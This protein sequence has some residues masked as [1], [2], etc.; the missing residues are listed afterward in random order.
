MVETIV[1][2]LEPG[3]AMTF[4]LGAGASLSSG[5]PSSAQVERSLME[6]D[7]SSYPDR[8]ALLAGIA[9]ANNAQ[10]L[11]PIRPLFAGVRPFIGYH[12]LAAIGRDRPVFVLNLNWDGALRSACEAIDVDFHELTVDRDDHLAFRRLSESGEEELVEGVEPDF[13]QGDPA[14]GVYCLHIHGMIDDPIIGIRFGKYETLKFA[15]EVKT[16]LGRHF[17][18]H[19]AIVIGASLE[20]EYDVVDLL[21]TLTTEPVEQR[22]L[23][24]PMY[25]FSR[26]EERTGVPTDKLTQHVLYRRTPGSNFRGD[27]AV[28]FDRLMLELS[29]R[30]RG[31][32]L[33]SS[34]LDAGELPSLDQLALPSREV[35]G[36]PFDPERHYAVVI[37]GDAEVGKTAAVCL[38]AHIAFLCECEEPRIEVHRGPVAGAEALE[39]LVAEPPTGSGRCVVLE[40]PFGTTG[41]PRLDPRFG[42]A[43]AA[44]LAQADE[45]VGPCRRRLLI[46]TRASNWRHVAAELPAPR[47]LVSVGI[48]DWYSGEELTAYLESKLL[49]S[50]KP[51]RPLLRREIHK[52]ELAL[53]AAIEDAISEATDCRQEIISE[54]TEFLRTISEPAQWCAILARLQELWPGG[55]S[56]LPLMRRDDERE[57]AFREA[58]LMLRDVSLDGETY[59]VPAHSTDREAIDEF[60]A[61]A[62]TRFEER[63]ADLARRHGPAEPACT[64]WKAIGALRSGDTAPLARLPE[65]VRANWGSMFLEEAARPAAPEE[66][67]GRVGAVRRI[68]LADPQSFWSRRELVFETIRLWPL[69][70]GERVVHDF[71]RTVLREWEFGRYLVLEAMLYVQAA[72]YP[73]AWDISAYTKIWDELASARHVLFEDPQAHARELALMF[74]A[75]AWCPPRLAPEELRRWI[76]P[77]T[78]AAADCPPLGAGIL[79][80][81]IYHPGGAEAVLLDGTEI[82]ERHTFEPADADLVAFLVRW[83]FVHQSRARALVYRRDLEPAHAYLLS[84]VPGPGAR[85]LSPQVAR[86]ARLVIDELARF[87]EHRGWAAHMAVGLATTRLGF[88]TTFAARHVAALGPTDPGAI[89][90]AATYR[91][92]QPM[93]R[94]FRAY[95][96]SAPNREALLD[97]LSHPLEVEGVEVG[98]PP[99]C[100]SRHPLA[101]YSSLEF[102]WEKLQADGL[103]TGDG[104]AMLEL[105]H[106]AT[107][108]LRAEESFEDLLGAAALDRASREGTS[109]NL[110]RLERVV[111]RGE[112]GFPTPLDRLRERLRTVADE[113]A[114]TS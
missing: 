21:R 101:L 5:A 66:A 107:A 112:T 64:L 24:T 4:V 90:A 10:K 8:D 92:P 2:H 100:A 26:Q 70:R 61:E 53:P 55:V 49:P 36:T 102:G 67:R 79:A 33:G 50:Q 46:T 38:I 63:L 106:R 12:C 48:D 72:T 110:G 85:T 109:G 45:E 27:P 76:E 84:R 42:P 104:Y 114:T 82:L 16:L 25:V 96:R 40:D 113:H 103:P 105:I 65:D 7:P 32:D 28:D 91:I 71:I 75:F 39:Q 1:G 95:F 77:L 99:F 18:S 29:T 20:G 97:S 73:G 68:L 41:A 98:P 19:P 22:A 3:E 87:P 6:A 57:P 37:E 81:S 51:Q 60:F 94:A 43:F 34:F 23:L 111:L 108:E 15:P 11:T 56:D 93:L 89:T 78:E 14:P 44:Y 9:D 80:A 59:V 54:K 30:L 83:H 17:F 62:S 88:D 86:R 13:L 52:G 47:L 74:D 31:A 58:R 69:L 35:L